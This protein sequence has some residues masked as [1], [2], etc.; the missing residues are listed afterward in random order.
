MYSFPN[1]EPVHC[2]MSSSNCCC[3]TCI[4]VSQETGKVVWYSQLFK[5]FPQFAVIHT[6]KDFSIVSEAEVDVF[7]EFS[8]FF[9]DPRDVGNLISNSSIF[10]KSSLNIWNFTVHILLKPGLENFFFFFWIY[11]NW[12]LIILQY[13]GGFC[14]TLTWI[15]HGCTCVPHP[16]PLSHLPPHPIPQGHPS[17]PALSTPSH[18]WNLDWWS[19][20]HVI[21]YMFQCYS[22][23]SS[24]PCLLPQSSKVCSLHLCLC[25]PL[26]YMVI[27]TIF[28]NSIY[29]H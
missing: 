9:Y 5:K 2:S 25:C 10:S 8:C 19:I 20:S 12:R 6:V 3:S 28:L 26:A 14:H 21:I 1:L 7:L 15:S 22:L 17:A 24:H 16:D 11:F 29:M 23:K 27:V 13:C 18:A 4:Q